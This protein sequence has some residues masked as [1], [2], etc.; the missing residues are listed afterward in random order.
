MDRD[1]DTLDPQPVV[2]RLKSVDREIRPVVAGNIPR[3]VRAVQ[4]FVQKLFDLSD[5]VLQKPDQ[6]AEEA[7]TFVLGLV[8]DHGEEMLE[9]ISAATAVPRVEVNALELDEIVDLGLK[10][11]EVNADF[12][13]RR[14][15]PLLAGRAAMRPGRGPTPSSS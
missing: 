1:L 13:T 12:F 3:L 7:I 6:H 8:A 15:G 11:W 2:V 5:D 14:L 10:A 9:A 4:P